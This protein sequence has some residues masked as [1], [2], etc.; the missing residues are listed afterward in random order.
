MDRVNFIGVAMAVSAVFVL[1]AGAVPEH[2][3]LV[4]G[5]APAVGSLFL[6]LCL[7]H[8][9]LG[10]K[11]PGPEGGLEVHLDVTEEDGKERHIEGEEA[12]NWLVERV[13]TLEHRMQHAHEVAVQTASSSFHLGYKQG[14]RDSAEGTCLPKQRTKEY[15]DRI[16]ERP[17]QH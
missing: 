8:R 6:F 10:M 14:M 9:W 1:L 5:V 4:A 11:L 17:T 16:L 7:K 3:H 13:S 2:A 12:L 15:L